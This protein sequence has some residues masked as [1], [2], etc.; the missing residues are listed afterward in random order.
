MSTDMSRCM[1]CGKKFADNH[2]VIPV[3]RYVA[4]ERR[5]DFVTTQP[6]AFIHAHHIG[7]LFAMTQPIGGSND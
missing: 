5:G 1:A 6:V 2:P 4:N 7:Q 3:Q